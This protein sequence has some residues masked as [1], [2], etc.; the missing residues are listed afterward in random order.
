MTK[1]IVVISVLD[2]WSM[3]K[4]SGAQSLWYTLK[5]YSDR[6]WK[7]FF[8]TSSKGDNSYEIHNNNIEVIRLNAS[9]FRK[10]ACI[11]KFGFFIRLQWSDYRDRRSLIR[12]CEGTDDSGPG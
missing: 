6:G 8:L 2:I 10:C 4:K 1:C 7:V 3:G 12:Q 9:L 11:K 5:G